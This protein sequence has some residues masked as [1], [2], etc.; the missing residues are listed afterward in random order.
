MPYS[1]LQIYSEDRSKR[2]EIHSYENYR[3]FMSLE[4]Q[5]NQRYRQRLPERCNYPEAVTNRDRR[6]GDTV[7][8]QRFSR[9]QVTRVAQAARVRNFVSPRNRGHYVLQ[10]K[11]RSRGRKGSAKSPPSK[12]SV[13]PWNGYNRRLTD[14]IRDERLRPF[15]SVKCS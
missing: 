4:E 3:D 8:T 10:M 9:A 14:W 5:R 13:S 1:C 6:P 11:G 15:L 2:F 7:M 12:K